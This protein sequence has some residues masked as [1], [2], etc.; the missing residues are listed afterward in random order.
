MLIVTAPIMGKGRHI[1]L[2]RYT[3]IVHE[4]R[5]NSIRAVTSELLVARAVRC[6]VGIEGPLEHLLLLPLVLGR[7]ALLRPRSLLG[8]GFPPV[9]SLDAQ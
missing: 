5:G 4:G 6:L 8:R 3:V 7:Q 2:Q 1:R 9:G